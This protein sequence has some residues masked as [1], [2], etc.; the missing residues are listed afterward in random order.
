MKQML[1][2]YA[3]YNLW[4]NENLISLFRSVDDALISQHIVSSFP[5][6]RATL[7]HLW[8][9]ESLWFERLNGN[10]PTEFPSKHFNGSNSEIF[11]GLLKASIALVQFTEEKPAPFYRDK[12]K[13]LT[14]SDGKENIQT[15]REMILH[16]INHST[17]HR[18]QLIM[19]CRQLNLSP[20][21]R[22]DYIIYS[23]EV[24]K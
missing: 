4:A 13:F 20:I 21:P 1:V 19:M 9:C 10:S 3:R 15:V 23:R 14:L 12:C 7:L 2:E 18:G 24:N 16:C 11:D 22:T 8:D 5:S 6:I 17:S